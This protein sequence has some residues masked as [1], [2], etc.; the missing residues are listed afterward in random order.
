MQLPK[1]VLLLVLSRFRGAKI[2]TE[3]A[4]A[5]IFIGEY[6]YFLDFSPG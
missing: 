1:H 2:T 4:R 6:V 3:D 5:L